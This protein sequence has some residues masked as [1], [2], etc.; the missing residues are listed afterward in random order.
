ME[1]RK[2]L[3][4]LLLRVGNREL[5][6]CLQAIQTEKC[7]RRKSSIVQSQG[8]KDRHAIARQWNAGDRADDQCKAREGNRELYKLNWIGLEVRLRWRSLRDA[9]QL[10]TELAGQ[11]WRP[12]IP[13]MVAKKSSATHHPTHYSVTNPNRASYKITIVVFNLRKKLNLTKPQFWPL[14]STFLPTEL[15]WVNCLVRQNAEEVII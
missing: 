3:F 12:C 4:P 14:T 11:I 7:P 6:A 5:R 2:L 13:E 8:R 10:R 15:A 1:W 9:F